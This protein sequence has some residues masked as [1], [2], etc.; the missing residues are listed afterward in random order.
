LSFRGQKTVELADEGTPTPPALEKKILE[1][2]IVGLAGGGKEGE[3]TEREIFGRLGDASKINLALIITRSGE[4]KLRM[5]R[6]NNNGGGE[7]KESRGY[8]MWYNH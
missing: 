6:E 8:Q 4:R 5:K 2:L 1:S 3:P 7:R